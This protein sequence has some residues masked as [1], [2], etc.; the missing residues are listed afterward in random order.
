MS[1]NLKRDQ[2]H[3]EQAENWVLNIREEEKLTFNLLVPPIILQK[4]TYK[5]L[6]GENENRLRIYLGLEAE[7]SD[8]KHVIC[9][10][11]VSS[12]LMEAEKYSEIMRIR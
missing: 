7:K 1:V 10:Y 8:G 2:V 5:S 11:A 3:P 4:E 12:F 9:A 6:A